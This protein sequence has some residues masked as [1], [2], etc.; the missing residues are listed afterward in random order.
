[1]SKKKKLAKLTKNQRAVYNTL[2]DHGPLPDH[3][4]VP[5][6]VHTTATEQSSSGIRTRR[7]ELASKGLVE[8]TSSV[9]LH[10]GRNARIWSVL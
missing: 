7:S 5:I 3:A 9:K 2:L 4:L 10:S 6:V 1:M 8:P